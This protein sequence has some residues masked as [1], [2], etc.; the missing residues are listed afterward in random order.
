MRLP[1]SSQQ[2]QRARRRLRRLTRPAWLGTIRRTTPLSDVWGRDRGA[3]V[4]RYYIERFL[5]QERHRIHG[6]VLEVLNAD[7]TERFGTAVDR[8]DVLD[9]DPANPAATIVADLAV[10][11]SIPSDTFDCFILTQT[12]Q[13]V[14]D[15]GAAVGHAHRVLR[16]GGTL[17]C[18]VPAV[19]RIG[20][21]YL[22]TE[23]WRF[24]PASC[25]HLFGRT[26]ERGEVE[27]H[28]HGNVLVAVA[29][30]L[31]MAR[32]ELSDRELNSNDP[33]FPVV[34]TVRATKAPAGRPRADEVEPLEPDVRGPGRGQ[35]EWPA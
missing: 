8:Y 35:R 7:Y 14:F 34:I 24:T 28:S 15:V 29:F 16:P 30:L 18:T 3:P 6:R 21:R 4:D 19:S 5:A 32:E 11:D 13:F 17:L 31:G 27:V 22:E 23:F 9:V 1:H 10:A 20:R 2:E 33:F 25:S 26:F 12:L